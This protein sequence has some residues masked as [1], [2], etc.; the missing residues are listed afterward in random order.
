VALGGNRVAIWSTD[1]ATGVI[2]Q[3]GGGRWHTLN[4]RDGGAY[5]IRRNTQLSALGDTVAVQDVSNGRW[6]FLPGAG[7][8]GR[9]EKAPVGPLNENNVP[10]YRTLPVADGRWRFIPQNDTTSQP[11]L[12][13]DANGMGMRRVGMFQTSSAGRITVTVPQFGTTTMALPFAA[14]DRIFVSPDGRQVMLVA[15]SGGRAGDSSTVGMSVVGL[16]GT[17]VSQASVRMLIPANAAEAGTSWRATAFAG[18]PANM[19]PAFEEAA[20]EPLRTFAHYGAFAP[21][22]WFTDG[23][24][25]GRPTGATAGTWVRLDPA[26]GTQRVVTL[27]E[28]CTLLDASRDTAWWSCTEEGATRLYSGR[29]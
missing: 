14:S 2:L 24:L 16:D 18:F 10:A 9:T 29:L 26:T 12:V 8:R 23:G 22:G 15:I 4:A 1:S 13:G 17:A 3:P 5:A 6:V 25:W 19:R 27:G 11:V 7:G 20:A 28:G 21:V